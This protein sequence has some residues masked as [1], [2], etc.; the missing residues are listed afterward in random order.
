ML[1]FVLLGLSGGPVGVIFAATKESVALQNVGFATALVNMGAFLTAALIQS[2][3]GV[4]LDIVS[5]SEPGNTPNLQNYQIALIL[6]FAIS[7]LGVIA[8]LLL[9]E[10]DVRE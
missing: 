4:I 5:V 9:R 3:F 2:G 6:P 1:L 10:R 7:G 8:S